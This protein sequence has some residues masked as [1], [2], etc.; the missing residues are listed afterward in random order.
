VQF[1]KPLRPRVQSGEITTS[2]RIWK[3]PHVKVGGRYAL[4]PGEIEVVSIEGI[5][6]AQITQSLA[7]RSGFPSVE[8]LLKIAQHGSGEFIF[9]V[10]FV[11]HEPG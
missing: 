8:E 1:A 7:R 4:P 5:E 2:V 10:E 3:R 11:Y 9:L 6:R